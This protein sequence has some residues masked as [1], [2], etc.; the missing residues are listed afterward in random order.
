MHL[1]KFRK[2][3]K[4]QNNKNLF[5][6]SLR[7]TYNSWIAFCCF[8]FQNQTINYVPIHL[9]ELKYYNISSKKFKVCQ[10]KLYLLFISCYFSEQLTLYTLDT[11]IWKNILSSYESKKIIWICR[12]LKYYQLRIRSEISITLEITL[13]VFKYLTVTLSTEIL[14]LAVA[15]FVDFS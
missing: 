4:W 11:K 12:Q 5:L 1:N 10:C 3:E 14:I 9:I 8:V 7:K 2:S 15:T 13:N 6:T